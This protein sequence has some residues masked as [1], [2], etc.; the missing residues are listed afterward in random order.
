MPARKKK[1]KGCG[2]KF[3]PPPNLLRASVCSPVCGIAVGREMRAKAER[4]AHRKRKEGLRSKSDWLKLA[5]KEFNAYIRLRDMNEPC[6]S[7]GRY[8][9]G[10][11]HAGHYRPVGGMCGQALR[12][13]EINC[14]RQCSV[15][16]NWQSGRLTDYRI[17]LIKKIGI[18]L[19][20]W[21][22][23]DHPE[24]AKWSIEEIQAIRRYYR[25]AQ[26]Q[27]KLTPGEAEPF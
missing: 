2:D 11:Y 24:P 16:N 13:N 18:E 1:C 3:T 6:I 15:C 4:R 14:H 20:E 21:L 5:Q 9:Q 22:E 8:H 26:K 23:K 17:G 12:F 19:V 25:D 7:C 27:M 10:Q